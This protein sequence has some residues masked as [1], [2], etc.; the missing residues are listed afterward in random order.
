M[1]IAQISDTHVTDIDQGVD[2]R[3]ETAMHFQGALKHISSLPVTPDVVLITGDCVDEGRVTEY[4]RFVE[5]LRPLNIPVY[6]IPGNHDHRD[7][8]RDVF[9]EQGSHHH[10]TYIQYRV[11]HPAPLMLS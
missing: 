8:M 6:V 3:Y 11:F 1:I 7:H 2:C 10:P 4:Q 9:G 5:L